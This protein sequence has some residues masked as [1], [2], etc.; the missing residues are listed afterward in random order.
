[1]RKCIL[2]CEDN[3]DILEIAKTILEGKG[4]C[5]DTLTNSSEVINEIHAH[6]PELILMD[7]NLPGEG[8]KSLTQQIKEN[9]ETKDIPVLLFSA[10]DDIGEIADKIGADG[11]IPKPFSIDELETKVEETIKKHHEEEENKQH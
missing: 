10:S 6:E 5:V 9:E 7:L 3:K 4:Y 8:G 1:M 11:F 2:I